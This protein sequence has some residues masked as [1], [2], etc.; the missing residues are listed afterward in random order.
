MR[1]TGVGCCGGGGGEKGI[2]LQIHQAHTRGWIL[3]TGEWVVRCD[4]RYRLV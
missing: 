2:R 4:G 3:W 1:G